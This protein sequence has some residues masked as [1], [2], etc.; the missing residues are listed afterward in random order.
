MLGYTHL[1][2]ARIR[3]NFDGTGTRWNGRE[4]KK[5]MARR[6]LMVHCCPVVADF[7]RPV[8]EPTKLGSL[9]VATVRG[10]VCLLSIKLRVELIWMS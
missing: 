5:Q 1:R 9:A 2:R 10:A 6:T 7:V 3:P 4:M 8:V